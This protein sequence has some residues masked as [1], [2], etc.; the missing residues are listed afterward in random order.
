MELKELPALAAEIHQINV[1]K[2]FWDDLDDDD[3]V[4]ESLELV[5]S[6]LAECLESI[7]KNKR[8]RWYEYDEALRRGV[9][10]RSTEGDGVWLPSKE[11]AFETFIKSSVEDEL[12]DAMIRLLDL[13]YGYD[14]PLERFK[15]SD[16]Y[17]FD[18]KG[19]RGKRLSADLFI[20]TKMTCEIYDEFD[21][22]GGRFAL[23]F[24][25]YARTVAALLHTA[26]LHGIDLRRHVEAK[27]AYNR[28]RPFKHGKAF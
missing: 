3:K 6:E 15:D 25:A 16:R 23:D 13:G 18:F 21:S 20:L 1:E 8:A 24:F 7:R 28:T 14:L 9:P 19:I 11:E 4:M 17:D 26:K 5:V 12:A 27:I 2:G 22:V 10:Q